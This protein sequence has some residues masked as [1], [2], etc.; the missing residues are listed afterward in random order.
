LSQESIGSDGGEGSE[1]GLSGGEQGAANLP[2]QPHFVIDG[3][4]R[5]VELPMTALGAWNSAD[6]TVIQND[7]F[8][9]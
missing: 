2:V 4:Y 1:S 5:T 7:D 8:I 3:L 6:D 9:R